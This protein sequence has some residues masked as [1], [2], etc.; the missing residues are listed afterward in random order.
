MIAMI[1][2]P[3]GDPVPVPADFRIMSVPGQSKDVPIMFE[4][5][6][7]AEHYLETRAIPADV[8]AWY[9]DGGFVHGPFPE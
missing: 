9:H 4:N 7:Q 1:F 8:E 3:K 5:V 6:D 2:R